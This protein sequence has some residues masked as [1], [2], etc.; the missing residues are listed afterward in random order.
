MKDDITRIE[1]FRRINEQIQTNF[2]KIQEYLCSEDVFIQHVKKYLPI[3]EGGKGMW[4]G[5]K[6]MELYAQYMNIRYYVWIHCRAENNN[7][8][9]HSISSQSRHDETSKNFLSKDRYH[10]DILEIV[11]I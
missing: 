4:L 2:H 6:S 5:L 11:S 9:L 8:E 10:F 3:S 1:Q 7:L